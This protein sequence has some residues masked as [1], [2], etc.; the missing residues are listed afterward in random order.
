MKLLLNG[1]W[2]MTYTREAPGWTKIPGPEAFTATLPV[3]GIWDDFPERFAEFEVARN[4]GFA[5]IEFPIDG[6]PCPDGSLPFL[7]GTVWLQRNVEVAGKFEFLRIGGVRLEVW[8][9]LDGRFLG[10]HLGHSTGVEFSLPS[11]SPAPGEPR[12]LIV[13]VSNLRRDRTGCDIRGFAGR[14]G[15]I[16][17]SVE[18]ISFDGAEVRDLYFYAEENLAIVQGEALLAGDLAES[19]MRWEIRDP[20]TGMLL[21]QGR[22]GP[23]T[24]H[25]RWTLPCGPLPLWSGEAPNLLEVHAWVCGPQGETGDRHVQRIG[26]RRLT[27]QGTRLLLNGC[28]VILRGATEHAYFPETTVP[29]TDPAV[30]RMMVAKFKELGFNW[31]RFHTWVPPEEYL[32][33]AD[34]AGLMIQV[35]PPVG[36]G[37]GEWE[38]ILRTVR[39]HPSVVIICAGN[40]ELLDEQK[41]SELE[42]FVA[43][44]KTLAP[45]LLFNPQE[46][47]RGVEYCWRPADFGTPVERKPFLHNPARLERLREFSDLFGHYSWGQLSYESVRGDWRKIDQNLAIYEKPCLAHEIGIHGSFLDFSL[48]PRH[49]T[50]RA[51]DRI[52]RPAW[53]ELERAGFQSRAAELHRLSCA[54]MRILRKHCVETARRCERLAGYDLLGAI[55]HHWHRHGY[56]CGIMNEFFEIKPGETAADVLRYNGPTVL[57]LDLGLRR[58]LRAGTLFSAVAA[59]SH[60]DGTTGPDVRFSWKLEDAAGRVLAEE[61]YPSKPLAPGRVHTLGTIRAALPEATMPQK[62][63]VRTGLHFGVKEVENSWD[64]WVFPNAPLPESPDVQIQDHLNDATL[65]FLESGGRVLLLGTGGLP[66]RPITFQISVAGRTTGNLALPVHEHPAWG[67]FPHEGFCDWPFFPLLEGGYAVDFSECREFFRPILEVVSSFKH[68]IPQA[69]VFEWRVGQGRLLVCGLQLPSGDPGADWLRA[70]LL[71][72]LSGPEHGVLPT[73]HPDHLLQLKKLADIPPKLPVTDMGFDVL[74]QVPP[75]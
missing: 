12:D 20:E 54:W 17:R 57:L 37:R 58:S 9:W 1:E 16:T 48:A 44:T 46:A 47:L 72:Y 59:V 11:T 65:H 29:P 8:A 28:P 10:H 34:E 15:G 4:A 60:F 13:A 62:L 24:E 50:T 45:D 23:C 19:E 53:R 39:R 51:G 40:E 75:E 73:V 61:Q 5:E 7:E 42:G 26:L 33:A 67:G 74:G 22:E 21:L 27:T 52:Y 35:E 36:A 70:A 71:R 49:L 25:M 32:A 6:S 14:S 66:S 55:D 69:A 31:L 64:L 41:I 38:A 3:P 30:C 63:I 18:W 68:L 43:L 56:P 2:A